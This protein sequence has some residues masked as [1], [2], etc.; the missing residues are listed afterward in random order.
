ML[1][2]DQTAKIVNFAKAYPEISAVYLFG[3]HIQDQK[4]ILIWGYY[5]IRIWM[6]LRG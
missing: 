6:H 2:K 5:F 4:V 1:D 3:S